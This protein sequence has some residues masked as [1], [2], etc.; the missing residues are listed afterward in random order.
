MRHV[1][2]GFLHLTLVSD[3]THE[4]TAGASA[5]ISIVSFFTGLTLAQVNE[6]LQA[7]AFIVA[8]ISGLA[9]TY[10]YIK[11]AHAK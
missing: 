1:R 2:L 10:Y 11:K 9:A 4:H 8:I 3:V 6:W 5:S 7:G